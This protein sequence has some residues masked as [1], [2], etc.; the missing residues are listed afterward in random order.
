MNQEELFKWC[1]AHADE[2]LALLK[3]LAAIPS[4]SHHEEK[5]ARFIKD[6]LEKNG[7]RNVVIDEALN[8]HLPFGDCTKPAYVYTAHT[9]VVFPDTT[10]L[11]VREENGRLFAPG[12]GDDT[13]NVTALMLIA[14][15]L[16]SGGFKPK[17]PVLFVFN[18]CEEGLGNLKG[19]RRIFDDRPGLVK[20][21]VSFDGTYSGIVNRA[22]GSERWRIKAETCG[23]HSY[24]AF[25]NPNAIAWMAKLITK[26]D[27]QPVPKAEGRKTTYNFGVIS[28]GTS[29]NTIAQ[30]AEMLYE[31]R[32]D[33]KSHLS[34]MRAQ[35]KK[36]VEECSSDKARFTLEVVGERPCGAD[37]EAAAE[38]RVLTRCEEAI[39]T[40]TGISPKRHASST[41][42]NIPLSLGVPSATF[43]LYLGEK[44]HTREENIEISSLQPGLK[45]GLLVVSSHF[46][47]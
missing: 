15:Y 5:R 47:K 22:V 18:S 26:L 8:V 20:E 41:D 46:A 29:V 45:I 1:E 32:S 21:F 6:W 27:A 3:E 37:V 28:G 19:V 4:P 24:G 43:G 23:G 44:A 35:M 33:E 40:V 13:A 7:A 42:A 25:G 38:E 34:Q 17:D 14:K 10:P 36:A 12:V 16:I 39:K 30:N 9:D 31:Y 11:P 2:Q